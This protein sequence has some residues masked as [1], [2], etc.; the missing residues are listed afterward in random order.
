MNSE[1]G[2]TGPV[3]KICDGPPAYLLFEGLNFGSF[4]AFVSIISF[5]VFHCHWNTFYKAF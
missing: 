5:V 1:L 2:T 4:H 3:E